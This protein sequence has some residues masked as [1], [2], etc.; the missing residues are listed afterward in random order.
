MR[1]ALVALTIREVDAMRPRGGFPHAEWEC[2]WPCLTSDRYFFFV[3]L[4]WLPP[5]FHRAQWE[6]KKSTCCGDPFWYEAP[7]DDEVQRNRVRSALVHYVM[8]TDDWE[9]V[10][11]VL[12]K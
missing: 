11:K 3:L 4:G 1:L 9:L 2:S 12:N 7:P 6:W 8:R 5:E 10:R